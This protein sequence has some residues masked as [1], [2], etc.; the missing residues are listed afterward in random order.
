MSAAD[1]PDE[2][3]I[4]FN[5]FEESDNFTHTPSAQ[6]LFRSAEDLAKKTP[7]FWQN[8]VQPK[9]EHEC[10]GL[11]RFLAFPSPDGTNHYWS[12]VEANIAIIKSRLPSP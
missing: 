4:L 2:L 3:A 6:R 8:F 5:E 11:Y 7:Q 1:Y 12:A 9:L 10:Q